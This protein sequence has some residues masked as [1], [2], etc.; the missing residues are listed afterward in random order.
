MSEL[1]RFIDGAL[2]EASRDSS[3][4]FTIDWK[5]ALAKIGDLSRQY[6]ERWILYFV[7]AAVAVRA[8]R[9]DITCGS[10]SIRVAIQL[11]QIPL[12]LDQ[13]LAQ[14][15][16]AAAFAYSALLWSQ[17]RSPESVELLHQTEQGGSL[18]Q[19]AGQKE[20]RR[21]APSASPRLVLT[22]CPQKAEPGPQL[23]E[24]LSYC[25]VPVFLD[26]RPLPQG[27][28]LDQDLPTYGYRIYR[29]MVLAQPDALAVLA[30]A[31]PAKWPASRIFT[32]DLVLGP[33]NPDSLAVLEI[34]G[35]LD[36]APVQTRLGAN[37]NQL[38]LLPDWVL[39]L[40]YSP[41]VGQLVRCHAVFY[42]LRKPLGKLQLIYY[43][44]RLEPIDIPELAEDGWGIAIANHSLKTDFTGLTVVKDEAYERL[45][46]WAL[47][48][49]AHSYSRLRNPVKM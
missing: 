22:Y 9:V 45:R 15:E 29:R 31:P 17:A 25:P 12:D 20:T 42:R 39:P 49:V 6:P 26:T 5:H 21:P 44:L 43:G 38:Q 48:T 13:V 46:G 23:S 11:G 16:P 2:S 3:G 14:R 27:E 35:Q 4:T 40:E 30:A 47:E 10:E 32:T 1:D 37:G 34:A 33:K 24:V 28:P 19:I 8:L 18:Y 41:W 7:Q 36:H